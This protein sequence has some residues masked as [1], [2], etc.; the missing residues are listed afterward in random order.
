[1]GLVAD[2]LAGVE[3]NRTDILQPDPYRGSGLYHDSRTLERALCTLETQW[4]VKL[5]MKVAM[6]QS[7]WSPLHSSCTL[8]N[9]FIPIA[10]VSCPPALRGVS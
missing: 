8:L 3:E 5:E 7:P 2:T 4:L 1:M 9:D 10:M 6:R